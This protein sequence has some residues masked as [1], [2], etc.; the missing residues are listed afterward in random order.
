MKTTRTIFYAGI[1]TGLMLAC[2]ALVSG[3]KSTKP[4][5][6]SG[7]LSSPYMMTEQRERFPFNR[8]WVKPGVNKDSYH[9]II[10]SPV[11]TAYLMNNTGWKAANPRN[12]NLD[13]DAQELAQFTR[14]TFV[15]A[16]N[17]DP[18]HRLQ[19]TWQGGPGVAVLDLAIVELVPSK[20]AL[21]A[22]G[23]VAPF[24]G[25]AAVGVGS[26]VAGGNPSVAIEGR[27]YDS[28]TGTILMMFADREEPP[29]RIVDAKAVTWYGDAEDSIE[30]WA[31]QMVELANTPRSH[32]VDDASSFSLSPW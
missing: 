27:L 24:A 1:S 31:K 8:V 15:K 9:A 32:Q 13:T 18:H 2:I 5:P 20:A 10:V 26:K 6:D 3:C 21:G 7:Y 30:I 23:L 12:R 4:A 29:F 22:L 19:V 16:F 28:Q 11:N 25:A 17:D 14:D